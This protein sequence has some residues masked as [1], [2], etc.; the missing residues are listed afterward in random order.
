M[1]HT[2]FIVFTFL[3]KLFYSRRMQIRTLLP[4]FWFIWFKCVRAINH[5]C[6][7]LVDLKTAFLWI[8]SYVLVTR[9]TYRDIIKTAWAK[10]VL[11]SSKVQGLLAYWIL[12]IIVQLHWLNTRNLLTQILQTKQRYLTVVS[13][14]KRLKWLGL[15]WSPHHEACIRS[16]DKMVQIQKNEWWNYK[17]LFYG[18]LS[19]CLYIMS[20][21]MTNKNWQLKIFVLKNTFA[22]GAGVG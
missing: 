15:S 9:E 19:V 1:Q 13:W 6:A 11:I 14:Q 22:G 10:L 21:K 12:K 2:V 8:W 17:I 18:T 3:T 16:L 5:F 7:I 4:I 20:E